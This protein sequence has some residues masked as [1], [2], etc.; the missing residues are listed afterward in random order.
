MSTITRTLDQLYVQ[1]CVLFYV[2][3]FFFQSVLQFSVASPNFPPCK[4]SNQ[5]SGFSTSQMLRFFEPKSREIFEDEIVVFVLIGTTKIGKQTSVLV[6]EGGHL[7]S[8][9]IR[10]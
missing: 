2:F 8:R 5:L 10:P 6:K 3:F 1:S 4:L 9:K 7:A